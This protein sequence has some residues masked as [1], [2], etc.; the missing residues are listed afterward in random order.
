ML[1]AAGVLFYVSYWLI[2]Q[3]ESQRWID[4][5]SARPAGASTSGGLRH[6]RPDRVPGRLP[7]GGRDRPDVPGD[8]RHPGRVAGRAC[9]GLA[10][11]LGVG[12]VVLAAIVLVIRATSVRLPLRAFFQVTGVVLFGMAVVFAGNG[13]FELQECGLLKIDR[14]VDWLGQ[15][16]ALLGLYPERPGPLGPGPPAR[17][18]ARRRRDA[19]DRSRRASAAAARAGGRV[20][21]G[22]RAGSPSER[23]PAAEPTRRRP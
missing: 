3:S 7:R 8:D 15:G 20:E 9:S 6:A 4:S 23:R 11:G 5:S 13:V 2:S 19:P 10:A 22:P 14:R 1:A 17:R 18:G 16:I 12:L 21:R